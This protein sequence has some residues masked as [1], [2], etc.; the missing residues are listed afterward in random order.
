M[1]PS[2]LKK[3]WASW[4]RYLN[5]VVVSMNTSRVFAGIMIIVL[6]VVSK[7]ITLH[8]SKSME[9]FLKYTFSRNILIFSICYVGSRD[10]YVSLVLTLLFI[11]LMDYLLNE[12]SMFCILPKSFTEYHTKLMEN[13][14]AE[15]Q[16]P[17]T[18]LEINK[19]IQYL[20][21]LSEPTVPST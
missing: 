3:S 7:F 12:D 4:T 18:Q 2:S 13:M 15:S 21:K 17:P 14:D 20:A 9:S 5:N 1:N 11:I 8:F 19:A 16:S 6:N 10:V